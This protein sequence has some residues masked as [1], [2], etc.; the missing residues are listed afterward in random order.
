MSKGTR[1]LRSQRRTILHDAV[2]FISFGTKALYRDDFTK[3]FKPIHPDELDGSGIFYIFSIFL[4][5]C[6]MLPLRIVI[7]LLGTLA[8]CTAF[9][10]VLVQKNDA[11]MQRLFLFYVWVFIV[12]FG[13]KI[14]HHGNKRRLDTPHI[15][16]AN[17][18][19]FLDFLVLSS[20]KFCHASVSEVHGGLFGL[21]FRTFLT[22]NGSL[23]FRRSD[24]HDRNK[25]LSMIKEHVRKNKAPMLIFPEGTCVNNKYSV[26]FQ[27]G[28]F[29][30]GVT[31]LPVAIKYRKKLFDPYWNTS[32]HTFFVHLLYLMSRWKLEVDVYWMDPEERAKGESASDF[33]MRVKKKISE[34]AGLIDVKWN[35]YFKST[36]VL[37]DREL[38]RESF[39]HVYSRHIE[40]ENEKMKYTY[41]LRSSERRMVKYD[42]DLTEIE[43]D[44][45]DEYV[46]YNYNYRKY[47][48]AVLCEYLAMKNDPQKLEH[49]IEKREL[50]FVTNE[51]RALDSLP[52]GGQDALTL[53][54]CNA[55]KRNSSSISKNECPVHKSPG[56]QGSLRKFY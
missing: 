54:S 42:K 13:A 35:G 9:A 12:S 19:S 16:V 43:S 24:K 21:L 4:R 47:L 37:K 5:Y 11:R 39:K 23:L 33:A 10:F 25:I 31:I 44:E 36:P 46:F 15:F 32:R 48:D 56:M 40:E 51:V 14:K 2:D 34:K 53:C 55:N 30:L 45:N 20:H 52:K 28:V 41:K 26:L 3:C 17:H 22:K 27:K 6:V 1:S 50:A 29:D 8:F 49:V 7:F 18:T 38:L